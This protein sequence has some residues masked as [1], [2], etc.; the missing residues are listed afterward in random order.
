MIQFEGKKHGLMLNELNYAYIR[1]DQAGVLKSLQSI[2]E[3]ILR[4][5]KS[6][7]EDTLYTF[8]AD[9]ILIYQC[10]GALLLTTL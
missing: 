10:R 7:I 8:F 1:I 9:I 6:R 3:N 2:G 5:S 4:V